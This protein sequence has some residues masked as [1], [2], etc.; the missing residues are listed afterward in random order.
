MGYCCVHCLKKVVS[1][2]FILDLALHGL[3]VL[4]HIAINQFSCLVN[5]TLGLGEGVD[6]K[7]HFA[8]FCGI[9]IV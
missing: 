2:R 8:H 5:L 4:S 1:W 6:N 9:W 3:L 7:M